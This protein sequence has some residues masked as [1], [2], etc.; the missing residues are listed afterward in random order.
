VIHEHLGEAYLKKS[1]REEAREAWL[2]ALE[3]DPSNAQ[4]I[5]RFKT[6]GFGDPESEERFQ[7]AKSKK[8]GQEPAAD[9]RG[10]AE[11]Q[12]RNAKSGT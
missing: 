9:N 4:L 6:T 2:R 7:R 12:S 5:E 3:L 11:P 10:S 1:R 8:D